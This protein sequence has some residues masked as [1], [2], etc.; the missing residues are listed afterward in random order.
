MSSRNDGPELNLEAGLTVAAA[1]SE[2]LR[3]NRPPAM[4]YEE[5]VLFL[6]KVAPP[7]SE[8]LRNRPGPR[9]TPFRLDPNSR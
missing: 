7:T 6:K 1:D 8:Q 4:S 3:K 5:Y 2:A 9:G